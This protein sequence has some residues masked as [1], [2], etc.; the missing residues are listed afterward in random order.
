MQVLA[1]L[2]NTTTGAV[3]VKKP[4]CFVFQNP[5]HQVMSLHHFDLQLTNDNISIEFYPLK[6]DSTVMTKFLFLSKY[7]LFSVEFYTL[8]NN[9]TVLAK[10]L[11][12]CL[13]S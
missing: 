8:K 3:Y 13:C 4:K 10:L 6:Q 5:D 7:A 9:S 11:I 2:L 1:G 12:L